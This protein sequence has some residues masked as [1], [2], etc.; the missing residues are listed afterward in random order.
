MQSEMIRAINLQSEVIRAINA[1]DSLYVGCPHRLRLRERGADILP[2]GLDLGR[3]GRA[4]VVAA[5]GLLQ[6]TV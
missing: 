6:C 5:E 4:I 3:L 2:V 1:E